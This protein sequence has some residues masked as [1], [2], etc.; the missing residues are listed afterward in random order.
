MN[1]DRHGLKR[2]TAVKRQNSR[3]CRGTQLLSIVAWHARTSFENHAGSER[4]RH[5]E[6]FGPVA[7]LGSTQRFALRFS[8]E[9]GEAPRPDAASRGRHV[10]SERS[11]YPAHQERRWETSVRLGYFSARVRR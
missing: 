8:D 1:A 9:I 6:V 4:H 5:S 7:S 3:A 10:A 11:D 2:L